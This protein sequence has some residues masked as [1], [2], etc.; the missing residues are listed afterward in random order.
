MITENVNLN[1][2]VTITEDG[3]E[4]QIVVFYCN[5]SL[6]TGVSNISMEILNQELCVANK[7]YVQAQY[8]EFVER[9]RERQNQ[10]GYTITF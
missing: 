8:T 3:V 1:Y 9:V 4:K 2:I 10:V 7:E 6:L 5:M